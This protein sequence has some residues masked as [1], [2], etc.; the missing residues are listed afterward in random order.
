ML[1]KA[2]QGSSI[3]FPVWTHCAEK[4]CLFVNVRL[5]FPFSPLEPERAVGG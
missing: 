2:G 4:F 1:W 5:V 3:G